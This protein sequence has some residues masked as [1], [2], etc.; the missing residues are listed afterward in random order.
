MKGWRWLKPYAVD[1]GTGWELEKSSEHHLYLADN[2]DR[3]LGGVSAS[4]M[5]EYRQALVEETSQDCLLGVWAFSTALPKALDIE[6]S[7]KQERRFA[8]CH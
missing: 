6:G 7:E 8:C 2:Q 1:D 4:A 3:A 5:M